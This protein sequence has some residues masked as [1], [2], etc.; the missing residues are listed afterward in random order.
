MLKGKTIIELTDVNTGEVE[1][2]EDENM[3][4][5]ALDEVFNRAPFFLNN[6]LLD[7]VRM[8]DPQEA[9]LTPIYDH[10]LG[11]VLLFGQEIEEDAD[12]LYAPHENEPI[13]IGSTTPVTAGEDTRIGTLNTIDSGRDGNT[14]RYVWDFGTSQAVGRIT[15]VCLTSDRGGQHFLEGKTAFL[16]EKK[17]NTYNYMGIYRSN[18]DSEQPTDS[19]TTPRGF[20]IG[21]DDSGVYILRT[22]N[23]TVIRAQS[24]KDD[25][26]LF[27]D[28]NY[29]V[30]VTPEMF[31]AVT[32]LG[33]FG[34][35]NGCVYYADIASKDI[36]G[37]VKEL[38][39][40]KIELATKAKT[41]FYHYINNDSTSKIRFDNAIGRTVAVV[42]DTVY[43]PFHQTAEGVMPGETIE[44]W[45]K[46]TDQSF[47][48]GGGEV[49]KI[50]GFDGYI[51]SDMWLYDPINRKFHQ[52][53]EKLN[54]TPVGLIGCWAIL[55]DS[56]PVGTYARNARICAT[57]FMPYLATINN[58]KTPVEKTAT[59][60]MKVTYI[61]TNN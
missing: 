21:A 24:K 35:G 43:I 16:H 19:D 46:N 47:G 56:Y 4:T 11:G 20:V 57:V 38:T 40:Y 34:Y 49:S 1:R 45:G 10:A 41:T 59:K 7:R 8:V 37:Y 15:T 51:A 25:L 58:L 23:N 55:T 29:E 3:F 14:F 32:T 50:F 28:T 9:I 26:T 31:G 27:D 5:N 52:F 22:G 2:Y 39:M 13:G 6:A 18:S 42:D 61:V 12:I 60:T 30:V 48:Y 17:N 36:Y 53:G 33:F 54:G 44:A